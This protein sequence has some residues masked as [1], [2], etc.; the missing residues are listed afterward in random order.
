MKR[1]TDITM[2][3][4]AD[5]MGLSLSTVSRALRDHPHINAKTKVAVKKMAQK[6]GYKYNA[7]AASLR[8][9]KT[10]TIGLIV[11]RIDR[12]YQATAIMAIQ[13]T[14]HKAGYNLM[15][16]QSNESP[17]LERELVEAFYGLRVEGLIVS[18][19]LHTTDFSA[20]DIFADSSSP[21]VFFDRFPKNYPAH[22][23]QGDDYRGGLNAT[24]HLIKM[25]CKR[26]AHIGGAQT[27]NIYKERFE[28]YTDALKKANIKPDESLVYFHELTKENAIKTFTKLLKLKKVPD[29]I[30]ACNDT[31]A[32]AIVNQA[33]QLGMDLPGDLKIVG[34]SND[35]LTGV[36]YPT[37]SSIEQHPSE[38]GRQ[39]ATLMLDLLSGNQETSKTFISITIPTELVERQSS[40]ALAGEN[41]T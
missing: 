9:S 35:P 6:L 30:F 14:L 8:K 17:G 37:I 11:P 27:C 33:K 40:Q 2:K 36:V 25:G 29:A 15:I 34:Y 23:I 22:K 16:C 1:E 38:V 10:N 28:G 31:T 20:F 26:I 18:T 5:A 21:L 32:L 3:N 13:N 7:L 4:I 24:S 41:S 12:Y 19:T 39:S